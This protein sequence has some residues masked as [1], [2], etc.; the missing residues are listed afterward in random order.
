MRVNGRIMAFGLL[1]AAAPA[2]AQAAEQAPANAEK[3]IRRFR[4]ERNMVELGAF[5]GVFIFSKTHDFYDPATAPQEPL[6]RASPD[7]GLRAAFFP[8]RF[9]GVEL[10]FSALPGSRYL[11]TSTGPGGSAFLYGFRGH[12]ILQ[13][14]MFRVVPFILGGY[15]L[16]GVSSP[17]AVAG[18]DVDPI[19][20]YGVGVKYYINRNIGVRLDLRHVV[21]AQ[22][23]LQ[24]DGTSHAQV[25]LGL[26]VA[27]NRARPKPADKPA[28]ADPDRD[29]DGFLNDADKC[30][31]DPGIAPDGCPDRDSD[32]DGFMDSVDACRDVPGVAPDGCPPKDRDKD[33][34]LDEVDKCPDE[35]GVAPDGCPI[36]DTDGDQILDPDDK[37]VTEPETRNGYQDTDGCPDQV[38]QQVAK[39]TGVI[40]GIYFQTNSDKIQKKSEPTLAKAARVLA[41]FPDVKIEISGHTDNVGNRDYNLDLSRRRADS[42]RTYFIGKGIAA[43]RIKTRGAGPDEPIADN[44]KA[45]GRAKNRRIEFKLIAE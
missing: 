33:S 38:P 44:K 3:P 7:L 9:L 27:L 22:A 28:P 25:L 17:T 1:L 8:A 4:P 11:A 24:T 30:P 39:F 6:R 31:D 34:F 12:A 19:G 16:M 20:H 13:L 43:E 45:S 15:G 18:K 2:A 14:P 36:R 26:V 29:K 42:V 21:G 5:G 32:G 35:P 40:R 10:E 37:C 23:A 41:E